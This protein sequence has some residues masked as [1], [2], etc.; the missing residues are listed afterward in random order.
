MSRRAQASRL[1]AMVISAAVSGC[2]LLP[3]D[4]TFQ[5]E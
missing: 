5:R 2:I 1:I 4:F 3:C